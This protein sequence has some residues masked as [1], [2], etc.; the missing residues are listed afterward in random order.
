MGFL[1]WSLKVVVS[2]TV[3]LTKTKGS[4][5][6]VVGKAPRSPTA[7][8]ERKLYVSTQSWLVSAEP[9]DHL[10]LGLSLMVKVVRSLETSPFVA[11]GSSAAMPPSSVML[12]FWS[13][14]H[15][16][17][18]SSCCAMRPNVS[19]V[20]QGSSE[21]GSSSKIS[22]MLPPALG[23]VRRAVGRRRGAGSACGEHREQQQQAADRCSQFLPIPHRA[24]VLLA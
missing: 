14:F 9:S 18:H 10:R 11:E 8:L 23:C 20:F 4:V 17:A 7:G 12:T 2:T 1:N 21:S 6:A 22:T 19:P 24:Y 13:V 16:P 5:A 15:N 3:A